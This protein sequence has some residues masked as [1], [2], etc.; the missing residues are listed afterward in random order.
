MKEKIAQIVKEIKGLGSKVVKEIPDLVSKI[1]NSDVGKM[2]SLIEFFVKSYNLNEESYAL[3]VESLIK[4]H[5]I[6]LISEEHSKE[7]KEMIKQPPLKIY[8]QGLYF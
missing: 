7:L 1:K 6:N 8:L 4:R 5:Q 2:K 3:L